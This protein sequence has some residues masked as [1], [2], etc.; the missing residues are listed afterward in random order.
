MEASC[1]QGEATSGGGGGRG[2]SLGGSSSRGVGEG[3]GGRSGLGPRTEAGARKWGFFGGLSGTQ[4]SME[5][6][7]PT[8][9]GPRASVANEPQLELK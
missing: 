2:S 3:G 9:N 8:I 4:S 1:R 5:I 7:G 6:D